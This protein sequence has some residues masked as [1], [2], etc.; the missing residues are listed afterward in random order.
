MAFDLDD[1][2]LEATRKLNGTSEENYINNIKFFLGD[3]KASNYNSSFIEGVENL[4]KENKE[5]K[6]RIKEY[7]TLINRQK[8]LE[9][10]KYNLM[11]QGWL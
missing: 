5:L 7:E 10:E 4:I 1:E 8:G 2:E 9:Q 3:L 11:K 6:D